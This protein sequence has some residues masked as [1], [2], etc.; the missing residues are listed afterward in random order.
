[1]Y[2]YFY[3]GIVLLLSFYILIKSADYLISSSSEAGKRLGIS[4]FVIGF[5]IIAIGT[6]LPEFFT[7]LVS[8]FKATDATPFII[9]TVIG[10]NIA[11]ILLVFSILLIFA[12]GFKTKVKIYD[13]VFLSIS[14]IVFAALIITNK[15]NFISG[16]AFIIILILYL[17]NMIRNDRR[18]KIIKEADEIF[19][20]K[21]KEIKGYYLFLI[22][23]GSLAG[24]AFGARGVILGIENIGFM[25]GIPIAF[26]T[27]TTVAFA[28]SLPEIIVTY[29]SAKRKEF[30]L[31]VGN[32]IGSNISNILFV[33]GFAM[34]L[35][36]MILIRYDI[37]VLGIIFMIIAT[38]AF[39]LLLYKKRVNKYHGIILILIYILYVMTI[40]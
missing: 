25:I 40:I 15:L 1:M 26:L 22:L 31:A 27:M 12:T 39:I 24:L 36:P 29:V 19:D 7:A 2:G 13:L 14:T 11:N 16:I 5:T 23:L 9:G 33:A 37:Y 21:F 20:D 6:S 38:L 17:W 8:I 18:N 4:K 28:T 3:Y 10:S 30:G 35:K 32:I 34:I